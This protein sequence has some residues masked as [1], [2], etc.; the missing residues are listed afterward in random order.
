M[1]RNTP[2]A[3]SYNPDLINLLGAEHQELGADCDLI[4]RYIKNKDFD[5]LNKA[6]NRFSSLL[7]THWANERKM[8]TYLDLVVSKC[9]GRYKD[10]RTEM[11]A[12]ASSIN[13]TINLHT[14]IP[15]NK[16]TLKDFKKDFSILTKA[17]IGRIR[18]E[19][20]YL[21]KEYDEYF[22]NNKTS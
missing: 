4:F 15:I 21:F 14:N 2:L 17:L 6:F 16:S 20:K 5:E 1:P 22:D 12:I 19:E 8:Y 18:Y 7:Q 11:R 13:S 3:Y 9:D 10:T